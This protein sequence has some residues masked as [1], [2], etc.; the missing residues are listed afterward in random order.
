MKQ[1][2]FI[3]VC[4][5]CYL[6]RLSGQESGEAPEM[7]PPGTM[8]VR[9]TVPLS[10][11]DSIA[12]AVA[13]SLLS[14]PDSLPHTVSRM[15]SLRAVWKETFTYLDTSPFKDS[16]AIYYWRISEN[17]GEFRP[18]QPD[19]LVTGFFNRNYVD[20]WGTSIAYLGNLGTPAISRIFSEREATSSFMFA[21]AYHIYNRQPGNFDFINTRTPYSKLEYQS[22]GSGDTQNER[23]KGGISVNQGKKL[24]FGFD[25]DFLY[26]RG[27]YNHQGAKHVD[28][29][30]YS[31]Y[32][33]DR[34]RYHFFYNNRSYINDE[35]GGI[36]DDRYITSPE[37]IHETQTQNMRSKDIPTRIHSTWNR[38]KGSRFFYTHRY[39]FGFE[40]ETGQVDEDGED[41]TQFVTVGSIIH[42]ADLHTQQHKFISKD[43]GLDTIY[44]RAPYQS[45]APYLNTG[46]ANDTTRMWN[47]KNTLGISL[48][49]GFNHWAKFDLTAYASFD[50]RQY[51][52]MELFPTAW[53]ETQTAAFVGGEITKNTG[54]FFRYRAQAEFGMWGENLGDVDV[55]GTIETRIPVFRDTASLTAK[56]S[57]KNTTPSFYEQHYH[58]NYFWWDRE[59]NQTQRVYVGGELNVP[60]TRSTF[61]IGVENVTNYIYFDEAAL[62]RQHSDNIQVLTARWNQHFKAGPLH[63]DNQV[64]YQ[65]SSDE[66]IIPLPDIAA[67]SNLYLD[68][69]LIKV[70][71][72]QLGADVHYFTQYYSPTYEAATQQFHLQK[73]TS[74]GN[75]PLAGAYLN[76]KLHQVRFFIN[77]YNISASLID[78][79]KYFSLPHYPFNP[80]AMKFGLSIDFNN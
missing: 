43:A 71:H 33:S 15:D 7:R 32:F 18:G 61:S 78:G 9:D 4:C 72:L 13:D 51:L 73:T 76:G 29:V 39:N 36:T 77:F 49:E 69:K 65:K 47:L 41:V 67:Y 59:F 74:I 60:H 50:Y 63:W 64:A 56:A 8:L 5:V 54:K 48:R 10:A 19:T 80:M 21:D 34:Y 31:S 37:A 17:L 55:S 35:N 44:H 22:E 24:N 70:L 52:L 58:S 25:L 23:L 62:P 66:G 57:L 45:T 40:K 28:L 14:P 12:I 20:G 1:I 75:Y 42:T 27:H 3:S 2:I 68:F 16:L 26:A 6:V 46:G 79:A 11:T 38:V 53:V 30:A